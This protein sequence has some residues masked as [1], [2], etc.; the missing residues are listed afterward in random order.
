MFR[1]Y[2]V[3]ADLPSFPIER[4]E[5]HFRGRFA[6]FRETRGEW[7]CVVHK[8]NLEAAQRAFKLACR[9]M[10]KYVQHGRVA[11]ISPSGALLSHRRR[12][13]SRRPEDPITVYAEGG[14]RELVSRSDVA[15]T[16]LVVATPR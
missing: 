9:S 1:S 12:G 2:T 4:W 8:T 5:A 6:V 11:L 7:S 13:T 15:P 3:A 14:R 16:L 10:E